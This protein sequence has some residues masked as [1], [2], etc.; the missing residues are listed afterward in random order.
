MSMTTPA[1]GVSSAS[2]PLSA[3][4]RA[5][6]CWFA[7]RIADTGGDWPENFRA[8]F[9]EGGSLTVL[10]MPPDRVTYGSRITVNVLADA[11]PSIGG[12][13]EPLTAPGV[14]MHPNDTLTSRLSGGL[15]GW[16]V[17]GH[18]RG[19]FPLYIR[20]TTEATQ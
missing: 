7:D 11:A 9:N 8:S 19:G 16:E 6:Q 3:Q 2:V 18:T 5:L 14:T 4:Q 13:W 20:P 17:V 10:N 1:D 12:T 15:S